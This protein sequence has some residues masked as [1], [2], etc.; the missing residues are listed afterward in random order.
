M[1]NETIQTVPFSEFDK[2]FALVVYLCSLILVQLHYN[3]T[4][5]LAPQFAEIVKEE[6]LLY[7]RAFDDLVRTYV[8]ESKVKSLLQ[9]DTLHVMCTLE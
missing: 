8:Q 6:H 5:D 7:A 1:N 9:Y 4:C 3:L 2:T